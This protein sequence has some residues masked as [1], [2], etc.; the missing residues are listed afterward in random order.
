MKTALLALCLPMPGLQESTEK[1]VEVAGGI[2]VTVGDYKDYLFEITGRA[3]LEEVVL[4]RI[5][6]TEVATLAPEDL[7]DDLRHGLADPDAR[8][9][10]A[11]ERRLKRDFGG[12]REAYAD[13]LGAVG[14]TAAEERTVLRVQL[15]RDLRI[16]A[17]VQVSRELDERRLRRTFEHHYGVDGLR[18]RVRHLFQGFQRTRKQLLAERGTQPPE[19]EVD[20][21]VR[22][23]VQALWEAHRDRGESFADLIAKG[24]DDPVARA[25]ARDPATRADAGWL[26]NYNFQAF[27]V[28]FA[29]AVRALQPGQVSEPV[30]T[31][32]G[33]HLI[34]L[35]DLQRT[36]FEDVRADVEQLAREEPPSRA[37]RRVLRERLFAKYR[38]K[39]ALGR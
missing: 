21:I 29:E 18:V 16:A 12:S 20:A 36:Q 35:D 26:R 19:E 8:V 17:L 34:A 13:Y 24:T 2:T 39:E 15:L 25:A 4:D 1:L 3:K 23:R 31:S 27:G 22:A 28:E 38:V 5:L 32:H 33:Y 10:A 6:E 9:D 14:R 7:T 30:R 11:L 37:E